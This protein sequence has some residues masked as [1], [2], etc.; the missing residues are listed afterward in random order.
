MAIYDHFVGLLSGSMQL[1]IK[2]SHLNVADHRYIRVFVVRVH[3]P[4]ICIQY[5][6]HQMLSLKI[7]MSQSINNKRKNPNLPSC[8]CLFG[9]TFAKIKSLSIF[10]TLYLKLVCQIY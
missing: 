1:R 8:K 4:V 6:Y 10:H 5:Q 9:S 2:P 3:T 7:Y